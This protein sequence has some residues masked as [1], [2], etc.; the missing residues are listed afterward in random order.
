[1]LVR[2]LRRFVSPPK[3]LELD[4]LSDIPECGL[5]LKST[6]KRDPD[7]HPI[8]IIRQNGSGRGLFSIVSSTLC[9]LHLADR[10][11]LIPVV[12][13]RGVK[14]E[15]DDRQFME[16]DRLKRQNPWDFFFE[17]VSSLYCE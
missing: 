1:M 10:F 2:Q 16:T 15:Y 11:G 5:F 12:D 9:H 7:G 17:T 13:L 6:G 8:Y 4:S 3:C 14:T